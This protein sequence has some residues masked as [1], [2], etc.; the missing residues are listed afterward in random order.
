MHKWLSA[1]I[2]GKHDRPK[3][4]ASHVAGLVLVAVFALR[5]GVFFGQAGVPLLCIR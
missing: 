5:F 4:R 1:C 3:R 2:R